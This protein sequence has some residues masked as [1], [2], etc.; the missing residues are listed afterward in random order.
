MLVVVWIDLTANIGNAI[1]RVIVMVRCK[2]MTCNILC[3]M[4]QLV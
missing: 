3:L 1:V 2:L 4:R